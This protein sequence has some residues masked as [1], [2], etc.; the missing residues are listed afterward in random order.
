MGTG[1]PTTRLSPGSTPIG[2]A[3]YEFRFQRVRS[4][5]PATCPV[6]LSTNANMAECAGR[7]LPR[8]LDVD[9]L[10]TNATLVVDG[11]AA[12]VIARRGTRARRVPRLKPPDARLALRELN[13]GC[14][15]PGRFPEPRLRAKA[16]CLGSNHATAPRT[17]RLAL[18]PHQR[19]RHRPE[20]FG[21]A[22]V[23][24]SVLSHKMPGR[25]LDRR[26]RFAKRTPSPPPFSGMSSIPPALSAVRTASRVSERPPRSPS[27]ASNLLI[28]GAE[29]PDR[30]ARS[31]CDHPNKALAALI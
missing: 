11:V 27:A 20:D 6:I 30:A 1:P 4:A 24:E 12:A 13:V 10:G 22:R 3:K 8:N 16:A 31:S 15:H 9:D 7:R 26:C 25:Y 23:R 29:R 18:T 28:V 14:R 21:G 5:N 17:C 19:L 2:R